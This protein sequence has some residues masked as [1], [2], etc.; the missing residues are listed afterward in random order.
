MVSC[1]V[2]PIRVKI[3][4]NERYKVKVWQQRPSKFL[5]STLNYY[6]VRQK[7]DFYITSVQFKFKLF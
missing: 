4:P 6:C 3:V 7:F 2:A 5:I 1:P